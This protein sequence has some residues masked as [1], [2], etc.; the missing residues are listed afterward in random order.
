MGLGAG[1]GRTRDDHRPVA[2]QLYAFYARV[3][4]IEAM[5]SVIGE[6]ELTDAGLAMPDLESLTAASFTA[7]SA[8]VLSWQVAQLF[9]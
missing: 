3:R 1:P 9:M 6:E 8:G 5:A 2:D 7:S 4:Q